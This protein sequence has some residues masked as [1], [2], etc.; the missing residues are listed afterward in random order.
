[1]SATRKWEAQIETS[2]L[3]RVTKIVIHILIYLAAWRWI[4][5]LTTSDLGG[6]RHIHLSNILNDRLAIGSCRHKELVSW[7]RKYKA[8]ADGKGAQAIGLQVCIFKIF[9]YTFAVRSDCRVEHYRNPLEGCGRRAQ[10][11]GESAIR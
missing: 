9:N 10:V 1:M 4:Y 2:G 5:P 7:L 8:L 11:G 3:E 6:H